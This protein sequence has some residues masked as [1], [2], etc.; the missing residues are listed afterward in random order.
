M[1]AELTCG[2]VVSKKNEGT[3]GDRWL[4]FD[5]LKLIFIFLMITIKDN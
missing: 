3:N 4:L 1:I 5:V 2:S